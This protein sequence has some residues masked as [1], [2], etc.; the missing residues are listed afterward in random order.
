MVGGVAAPTPPKIDEWRRP[1]SRLVASTESII[2]LH[3]IGGRYRRQFFN[4]YGSS[5]V[6]IDY[7]IRLGC[8]QARSGCRQ[9]DPSNLIR[10]DIC[11]RP[12]AFTDS[13]QE[14]R[15]YDYILLKQSSHQCSEP[16]TCPSKWASIAVR[17]SGPSILEQNTRSELLQFIPQPNA[18]IRDGRFTRLAGSRNDRSS[19][20]HRRRAPVLQRSLEG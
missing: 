18:N 19:A 11:R 15:I 9:P 5:L 8:G 3:I 6:K 17:L 2:A 4:I 10:I 13:T 14:P 7:L 20:F 12:R 1:R 16:S